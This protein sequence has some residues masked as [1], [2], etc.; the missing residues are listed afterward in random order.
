[1][2]T[3][4]RRIR[5]LERACPHCGEAMQLQCRTCKQY[6][7]DYLKEAEEF[8]QRLLAKF[9]PEAEIKEEAENAEVEK[10]RRQFEMFLNTETAAH[11]RAGA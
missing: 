8:Q 1:M 4:K 2:N 10:I 3:L 9:Q 5:K 6:S 11:R 7:S